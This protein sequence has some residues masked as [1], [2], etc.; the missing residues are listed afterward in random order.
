MEPDLPNPTAE[1]DNP[2]AMADLV[3][4]CA[5]EQM[6]I[7][8][9]GIAHRTLGNPPP[10]RHVQLTQTG[11]V[12][13]HY[14]RD[15]T[16]RVAAGATIGDLQKVLAA[17]DQF[18]PLDAD[19]DITL[20]EAIVHNVYGPLRLTYGSTR[21]L[22]LGLRYIDGNGQ[23]IHVGGRTV[24]NVAGYDVS[25]FMVGSLGQFGLVYEATLR[26]YA[27]PEQAATAQVEL[28]EPQCLDGQ[29]TDWLLSDAAPTWLELKQTGD[30]WRLSIGYHGRSTATDVQLEAMRN[31]IADTTGM[32]MAGSSAEPV[33]D[34]LSRQQEQRAW[35]RS[36]TAAVKVVVPPATTGQTC[37]ALSL[38]AADHEPLTIE[39]VPTHGCVFAGG[40]LSGA[41]AVSLDDTIMEL[42]VEPGGVR[43]WYNRPPDAQSIK[44]FGPPQ[45]DWQIIERLRRVMD[46]K[47][48]FNPGRFLPVES[49][50]S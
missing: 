1:I 33:M 20:G 14:E 40:D 17:K 45:D 38:W 6:P 36:A 22:I 16:V 24:K 8:D 4:D 31:L 32:H 41:A 19:D 25:R 39:A 34:Q 49:T 46:P 27:L 13:E 2:A 9:Y 47:S 11:G 21:D 12:I 30:S 15:M 26:T 35:R 10:E 23:D 44:P 5:R 3:R 18:L 29:L 43:A 7:V 37:Q 50:D 42:L 48:L 28:A